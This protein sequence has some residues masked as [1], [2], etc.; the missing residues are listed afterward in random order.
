MF[1]PVLHT[2]V[3]LGGWACASSTSSS[4]SLPRIASRR[5][6]QVSLHF[7]SLAAAFIFFLY[8]RTCSSEPLSTTSAID[9]W[10]PA[11]P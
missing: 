9:M 2:R 6:V 11:F 5:A 1:P 3:R 10:V 4:S 7:A 8:A